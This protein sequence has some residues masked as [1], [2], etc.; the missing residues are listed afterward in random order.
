VAV[1]GVAEVAAKQAAEVAP[2]QVAEAALV[3]SDPTVANPEEEEEETRAARAPE[4]Q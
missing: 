2:E 3:E 1:E 4:P